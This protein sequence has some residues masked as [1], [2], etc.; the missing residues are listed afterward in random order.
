MLQANYSKYILNFKSPA[1]T[2]RGVLN[3]KETW[4]IKIWDSE[5]PSIYGLGECAVFRGLSF[6]DI[7][8]YETRLQMCCENIH[9]ARFLIEYLVDLPSIQFGIETAFADLKNNGNR[10]LFPSNFTNGS[11]G[12][13]I[14]GLIWMGKIDFIKSQICE[15]LNAG[16]RCL[17]FKVGAMNLNEEYDI[18][19]NIR[20]EFSSGTLEIRLDANGAFSSSTALNIIQEFSNYNIHSIEQPIKPG[21]LNE[22]KA[23]CAHSPI[24]IALDEE[25]IGLNSMHSKTNLLSEIKPQYI[26]I[27]PA[28][29][30]GFKASEEWIDIARKQNIG[31]WITS[32]LES[33]VGLNAIAQWTKTLQTYITQGLGTGSL[34][35]NNIESPLY[36]NKQQLFYNNKINWDLS[37]I[38]FNE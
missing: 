35:T 7:V 9:N 5:N 14:N 19:K 22:M 13:P 6:D 29:V 33:N 37:T 34:F 8:D 21:N 32:A 11:E 17:K 3:T 23:I 26:I 15:K 12:I 28:L 18:L 16:Y 36:I 4:F 27:K 38:K 20:N 2:S 24:P 30:G 25:L 1:G 10:I 31:W